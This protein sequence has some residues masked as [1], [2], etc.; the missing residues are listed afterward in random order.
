MRRN[1]EDG[2][3]IALK[4]DVAHDLASGVWA[5]SGRRLGDGAWARDPLLASPR[6]Y[7]VVGESDNAGSASSIEVDVLSTQWETLRSRIV[8]TLS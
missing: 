5:V 4:L 8:F 2:I 7:D 1:V 6:F 3:V